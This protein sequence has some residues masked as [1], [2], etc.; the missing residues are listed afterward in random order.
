MGIASPKGVLGGDSKSQG[1]PRGNRKGILGGIGVSSND[2]LHGILV[3]I[4]HPPLIHPAPLCVAQLLL[5]SEGRVL[6]FGPRLA[7]IPYF[8]RLG[9]PCPPYTNPADFLIELCAIDWENPAKKLEDLN[10]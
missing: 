9:H 5:L 2:R 6:F 3:F 10:A 7:A 4:F 8:L 1:S